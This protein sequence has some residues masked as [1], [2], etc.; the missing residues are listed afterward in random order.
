MDYGV[1]G[2]RCSGTTRRSSAS[3][4]QRNKIHDP[5]YGANSWTDGHPAGPQGITFSDCGG[6][7]VFRYNEIYS[8]TTATTSTTAS[9]AR[10]T[11]P[12]AGFPN[13]DTDIYG[14]TISHTWDDAIEAE[15]GNTQRAHL[16]QLHGPHRHRR[17]EHRDPV[18]DRCTSSATC[19]TAAASSRR[20][21]STDRTTAH[22]RSSRARSG[23]FGNG[24]RY[25]FHN[26]M[27]QAHAV[28]LAVPAGRRRRH[29]RRGQQLVTNTVSR[30]NIYH[31]WKS[32][33]TRSHATAAA[34]TTSTTTCATATSRL[35]RRRGQRHRRHADLRVGQRLA[36]RGGRHYQLAPNSPGYDRGAALANF[37]DGF[38]G[39]GP[40]VGA[41]EAG[42]AAMSLA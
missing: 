24:R 27:L 7:H 11:S 28:G 16:G 5:R 9:A 32:S 36:E 21:R 33:W 19:T 14:N 30:N 10:T 39:A 12:T 29:R 38:T 20:R 31:V 37:N 15:G 8:S 13:A 34:A 2:A 40:D 26:T 42:T 18:A 17:R 6:N 41:H 4:I 25:V 1:G 23:G 3:S 35:R 22:V